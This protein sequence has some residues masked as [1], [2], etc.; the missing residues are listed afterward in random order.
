MNV[1][2]VV[3]MPHSTIPPSAPS[4]SHTPVLR[5][6]VLELMA[7]RPGGIYVDAT[8]GAGGHAEALLAAGAGHLIGL[9]RDPLALE[10]SEAR[11]ARFG[12]KVELV[13]ASF[14]RIGWELEAMGLEGV[15]GILADL[16]VSSMQLDDPDRGMSFRA[17][18][19]LDMRMNPED[20]ETALELIERLDVDDLTEL[21]S[22]LGEERRARRVARCIKQAEERDELG[23][24][25]DL[26]RAIVKAVG[27]S[28]VGGVDP[29][30][31]TFQ[32][33]RIAVNQELVQLERLLTVAPQCL[34]PGGVLAIISFHSLED[35]AVKRAFK[36]REVW[37]PLTKKPITATEDEIDDNP[38]SRSAKLRV[39]RYRGGEG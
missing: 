38:R 24:T 25:L 6:E 14:D 26:R 21:I 33:L 30:T 10:L 9:D 18:G 22:K 32:A 1:V 29:A 13:H 19:P 31:R 39:A 3:P 7:P 17:A 12:D 15:D 35:R 27:P 4:A 8:V 36:N 2:N 16:G 34:R 11:L 20:G 23:D 37:E 5:D 28:R